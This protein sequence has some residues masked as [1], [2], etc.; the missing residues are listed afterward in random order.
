MRGIRHC[1]KIQVDIERLWS[2]I[3][4]ASWLSSLD[5]PVILIA[6]PE[7]ARQ[8]DEVVLDFDHRRW[9][10]SAPSTVPA[11]RPTRWARWTISGTYS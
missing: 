8:L 4:A 5:L 9:R 3:K 11:P 10:A 2:L 6:V 7:G 1:G